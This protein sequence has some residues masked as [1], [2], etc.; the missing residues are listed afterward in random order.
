MQDRRGSVSERRP[1][2]RRSGRPS[3]TLRRSRLRRRGARPDGG[4]R[5]S[6]CLRGR[7]GE[8]SSPAPRA[9]MAAR[10]AIS[11]QG[12]VRPRLAPPPGPSRCHARPR[13]CRRTA[14][15]GPKRQASGVHRQPAVTGHL[16]GNPPGNT[17][18]EPQ[19]GVRVPA[20]TQNQRI[21]AA[22]HRERGWLTGAPIRRSGAALT[23]NVRS[24]RLRI[25]PVACRLSLLRR[26]LRTAR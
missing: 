7:P 21:W 13:A 5:I 20:P 12:R 17:R 22:Q 6:Q 23:R 8:A 19:S 26:L 16:P 25:V 10:L 15:Y 4:Q 2:G 11:P 9:M 14:P 18:L 1:A 24:A 3:R